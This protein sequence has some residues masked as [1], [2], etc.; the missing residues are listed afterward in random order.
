MNIIVDLITGIVALLHIGFLVIEMFLWDSRQ[1]AAYFTL[2]RNLRHSPKH[3]RRIRVCIMGFS[4]Q[5]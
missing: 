3:W 2:L 5:G 4:P 1:D